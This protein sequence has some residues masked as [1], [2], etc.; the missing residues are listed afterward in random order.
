MRR[1]ARALL[2]LLLAPAL[3]VLLGSPGSA[4]SCAG[5][6]DAEHL[7][8]AFAVFDGEVLARREPPRRA[9]MSSGDPAVYE[10]AVTRV[11]KGDVPARAEVVTAVSGASCGLELP[12]SGPALL[13]VQESGGT[14]RGGLCDGSRTG[15]GDPAVLGPGREP[16]PAAAPRPEPPPPDGSAAPVVAGGV[17]A[18]GALAAGLLWRRRAHR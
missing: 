8:R 13:F 9:I 17:V 16:A 11:Y 3:V 14:L 2:L 6:T 10:V 4:C 1:T 7:A 12:P 15:S 18:A 5:G